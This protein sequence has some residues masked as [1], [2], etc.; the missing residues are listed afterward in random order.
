MTGIMKV[1][2]KTTYRHTSA[3]KNE[4]LN[5]PDAINISSIHVGNKTGCIIVDINL[6]NLSINI[7]V[8]YGVEQQEYQAVPG[9]WL[10]SFSLCYSLFLSRFESG[11]HR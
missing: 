10:L 6:A 1:V 9:I 11:H 4:I 5:I 7:T 8:L 2:P 3:L